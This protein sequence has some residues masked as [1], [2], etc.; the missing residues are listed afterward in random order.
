MFESDKVKEQTV[1][2]M[3]I[4]GESTFPPD[5]KYEDS[6]ILFTVY[7]TNPGKCWDS[8]INQP[9]TIY[10]SFQITIIILQFTTWY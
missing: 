3:K 9:W 6:D 4:R 8:I 5:I 7:P 1:W 10:S 2:N